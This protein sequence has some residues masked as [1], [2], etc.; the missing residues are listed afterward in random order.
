MKALVW[1][2]PRIMTIR[3]QPEPTV[4]SGEIVVKVAYAGICG[5]ELSGYLGQNS[6]RVPPLVMGHEFSGEIVALGG[7]LP[8]RDPPLAAGQAVTVNPLTYC[9]SCEYCKQGSSHLCP[10]RRLI[11]AH[12]PGSFAEYVSVPAELV[13]PLPAGMSARTGALTEPAA[14]G[15][16]IATLAGAVEGEPCLV[17]GAG[18]IGLFALQTL[19]LHGA[20]KVFISERDPARL[21]MGVA[22]GGEPLDANTLDPVKAV[23]EATG[24]FGALVTVDAVGTAGTRQQCIS[25]TRSAGTMILCGLHEETSVMPA[26]EIIRR[27]IVVRGSFAYNPAN[28]AEALSLLASGAM[29]LDPWIVEA[30]LSDGGLWFDRLLDSSGNVSK[31]LLVP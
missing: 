27:E 9:G 8:R 16:R 4:Q 22:F 11:G 14:C 5:S 7:N 25:A 12:R 10:N 26:A 31:V 17:V 13:T 23:R 3:E 29:K 20:A 24:G 15:V 28:F 2:G 30:P 18:P 21:A 6:L 1:E 19:R